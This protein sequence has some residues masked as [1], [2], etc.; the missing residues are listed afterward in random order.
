LLAAATGIFFPL[1]RGS[2]PLAL[3][4][5]PA[6]GFLTGIAIIFFIFIKLGL[7]IDDEIEQFPQLVQDGIH[8]LRSGTFT[9]ADLFVVLTLIAAGIEF[10]ILFWYRKEQALWGY[11]NVLLIA[12][13]DESCLVALLIT[14]V[15]LIDESV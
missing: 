6:L 10:G 11:L 3:F 15:I 5:W 12:L 1:A 8:D 2:E 7:N 14:V 4:A 13:L 9:S